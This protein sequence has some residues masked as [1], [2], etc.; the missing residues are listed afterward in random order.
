MPIEEYAFWGRVAG[1]PEVQL[2]AY[3]V[4]ENLGSNFSFPANKT[5]NLQTVSIYIEMKNSYG[6]VSE[7]T[8]R[9]LI[10]DEEQLYHV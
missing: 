4:Q 9:V 6:G 3:V 2:T 1:R 8:L 7:R 5:R 10:R